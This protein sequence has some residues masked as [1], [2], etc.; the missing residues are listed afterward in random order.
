EKYIT[1]EYPFE[2]IE[3]GFE[4]VEKNQALKVLLHF[5]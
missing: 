2:M 3:K 4:M 5:K 1:H